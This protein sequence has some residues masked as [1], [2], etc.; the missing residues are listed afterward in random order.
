MKCPTCQTDNVRPA[1]EKSLDLL[2]ALIRRSAWRCRGCGARFYAVNKETLN[3]T[4]KQHGKS[5][6][7]NPSPQARQ[8]AKKVAILLVAVLLFFVF[9]KYLATEQSGSNALFFNL[10]ERDSAV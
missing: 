2:A 3:T 7:R 1:K 8:L 6:F 4:R 5:L 10:W 9:I